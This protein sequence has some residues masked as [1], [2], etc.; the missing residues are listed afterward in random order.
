MS[1]G[2]IGLAGVAFI[3]GVG[4][5]G[6]ARRYARSRAVIDRP[7]ERS[8]H[9]VPTPRGGGLA[10]VVVVL[11]GI[12][13]MA[14]SHTLSMAVA[15]ALGGGGALVAGVGWLDDRRG[16][17]ARVR[18]GIHLVAAA[19]AVWWLGG[20]TELTVGASRADVGW[21]GTLLALATIVWATNFYNFMDGIDGLAAGEAVTVGLTAALLL[22]RV[23]SPLAVLALLTAGASAGFLVWNWPPARIFMGDVGSGF[24]GFLFAALALASENA[25]TLPALVWLIL[26]GVFFVDTTITLVRRMLRGERW[27]A[28]HRSHAYQ[29]IVQSGWPHRRV[30]LFILLVNAALGGLAWGAAREPRRLAIHVLMASALLGLLYWLVE[31]R[32]PMPAPRPD[33]R[34]SRGLPE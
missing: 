23:G 28:A 3:A 16:V 1:V 25:G 12:V 8:L 13:V 21:P 10:I 11:T 5:T 27:Y 19:W 34:V 9:S 14:W 29:R 20:M 31:R 24:L 30:T 15:L 18:F 2:A 4:L 7:N 26:L 22:A 32:R 17:S 6:V 33:R